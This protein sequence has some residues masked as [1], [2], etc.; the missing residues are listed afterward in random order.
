MS[1][2][3]KDIANKIFEAKG[4]KFTEANQKN[5]DSI[6]APFK[7]QIK[8][9][10]KKVDDTYDK[11]SKDRLDLKRGIESRVGKSPKALHGIILHLT[12]FLRGLQAEGKVRF[13]ALPE[14]LS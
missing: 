6:I 3:F 5:I 11:E 7:E 2:E 8:D 14:C 12:K 13:L 4:Q 1:L 9:F 10:T